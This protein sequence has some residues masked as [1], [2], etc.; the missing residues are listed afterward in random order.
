ML[1]QCIFNIHKMSV[2]L[3]QSL[4]SATKFPSRVIHTI[5]VLAVG[6]ITTF[7]LIFTSFSHCYQRG[8]HKSSIV[9]QAQHPVKMKDFT[10]TQQKVEQLAEMFKNTI[11]SVLTEGR[12]IYSGYVANLHILKEADEWAFSL[13]IRSN[14]YVNSSIVRPKRI[15]PNH[16]ECPTVFSHT[17]YHQQANGFKRCELLGKE[18]EK[19]GMLAVFSNWKGLLISIDPCKNPELKPDDYAHLFAAHEYPERIGRI[20]AAMLAVMNHLAK[21]GHTPDQYTINWHIGVPAGTID[22][23]HT[24]FIG[25]CIQAL[26]DAS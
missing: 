8:L 10:V 23:I 21:E 13:E 15:K 25:N 24:R 3:G 9:I 4:R 16:C 11:S 5:N 19:Y 6:V 14:G 26:Y 7:S 18:V 1:N 2:N 22:V 20:C 17:Y 12:D